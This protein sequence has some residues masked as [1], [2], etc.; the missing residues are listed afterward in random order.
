MEDIAQLV[1]ALTGPDSDAACN[2]LRRLKSES[3]DSD[4]VY[5]HF[6][7]FAKMLDSANSYVRMRGF[8]MIC[9]NARWDAERRIDAVLDRCLARIEDEKPIAAR[10]CIQ[11]LPDIAKYRPELSPAIARALRCADPGRYRDTMR[12]LVAKD[13]Q[14]ALRKIEA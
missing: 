4:A 14:E 8:L 1:N 9:A 13:I 2:A 6:G 11:A 12:G 7:A 3:A 5:R 10:V